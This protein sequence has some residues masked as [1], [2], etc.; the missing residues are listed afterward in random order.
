MGDPDGVARTLELTSAPDPSLD[1][2]DVL[3]V[4]VAAGLWQRHMVQG[5]TLPLGLGTTPITTRT[6]AEDDDGE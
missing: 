2:G 3:S 5:M 4:E 1:Y 6:D